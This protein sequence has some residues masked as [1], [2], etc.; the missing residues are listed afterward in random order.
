MIPSNILRLSLAIVA[1]YAALLIFI[2]IFKTRNKED[3]KP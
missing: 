3:K 2:W 1:G